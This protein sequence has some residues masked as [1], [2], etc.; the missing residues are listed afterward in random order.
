[1]PGREWE[2]KGNGRSE[3]LF[4]IAEKKRKEK[5]VVTVLRENPVIYA[6]VSI[7][8]NIFVVFSHLIFPSSA[9]AAAADV[10]WKCLQTCFYFPLFPPSNVN[11]LPCNSNVVVTTLQ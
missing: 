4:D 7:L 1:M 10:L 3:N 9:E 8:A 6:L 2:E 11:L 5:K